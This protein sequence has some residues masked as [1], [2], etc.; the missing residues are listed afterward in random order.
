MHSQLIDIIDMPHFLTEE[1]A[2]YTRTVI[3]DVIPPWDL[4]LIGDVW[5]EDHSRNSIHSV[6][7]T[8]F[9]TV[10]KV[11]SGIC[12]EWNSICLFFTNFCDL[13]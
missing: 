4:M 7:A 1:R 8:S 5:E 9:T 6:N 2:S 13:I 3:P 12:F 11:F 10:D